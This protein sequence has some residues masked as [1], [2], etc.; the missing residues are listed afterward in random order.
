MR[1]LLALALTALI[2]GSGQAHDFYHDEYWHE[3]VGHYDG[4]HGGHHDHWHGPHVSPSKLDMA[5]ELYEMGRHLANEHSLEEAAKPIRQAIELEPRI[6]RFHLTLGMILRDQG[7]KDAAVAELKLA[8]KYGYGWVEEEAYWVLKDLGVDPRYADD[9]GSSATAAGGS[10]G[11]SLYDRLG[12][13][14]AI[15]AVVDNFVGRVAKDGRVNSFFGKTDIPLFKKR[16]VEQIGSASGGP[17]RYTGKEMRPVHEG[18]GIKDSQFDAVVEDLIGALT[19]LKVPQ[20]EQ[21]ELL[22]LLGPMRKDI[23]EVPGK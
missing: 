17:E 21:D 19:E 20:K 22:A 15:S 2:A 5:W 18:M 16:L 10:D 7:K 13:N 3:E 12:G 11:R 4:H 9:S 6:A 1:P 14:A 8:R 23:V